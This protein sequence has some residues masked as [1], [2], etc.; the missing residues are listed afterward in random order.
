MLD[1]NVDDPTDPKA[2]RY[3]VNTAWT[4]FAQT[5]A[6]KAIYTV[7][8]QGYVTTTQA[9][10][11]AWS[12][13]SNF[14]KLVDAAAKYAADNHI[15]AAGS[16]TV[17]EGADTGKIELTQAGYYVVTSTLGTRAMIESTPSKAAVTINEKNEEDSI[18][19]TVKEDSTQEYGESNDAQV[20]WSDTE[21]EQYQ[22][23]H[24][25]GAD[26]RVYRSY[27]KD[28]QRCGRRYIHD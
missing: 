17:A 15:P 22:T 19:K 21:S 11:P 27:D 9:D 5:D 10:Q 14:S 16:V 28:R 13:E 8:L 7:D 6:F 12:G 26:N 3:T 1:L 24:R 23:L 18:E 4:A 20:G 2:F 25:R